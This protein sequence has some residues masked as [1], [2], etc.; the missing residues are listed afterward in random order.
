VYLRLFRAGFDLSSP[1]A[2]L[3]TMDLHP[4]L[5]YVVSLIDWPSTP[6]LLTSPRPFALSADGRSTRCRHSQRWRNLP[7]AVGE[8]ALLI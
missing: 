7:N 5:D 8:R 1:Q 2:R 4:F 6:D 3:W